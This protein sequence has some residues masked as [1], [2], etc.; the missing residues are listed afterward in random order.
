MTRK[1]GGGYGQGSHRTYKSVSS[2]K[3]VELH[4]L[5]MVKEQV[6]FA[7]EIVKEEYAATLREIEN[8]KRRLEEQV[9]RERRE[10]RN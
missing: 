9:A 8:R 7:N 3:A 2:K 4:I 5:K 6:R 1:R 10:Q